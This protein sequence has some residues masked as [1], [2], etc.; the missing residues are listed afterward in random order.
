MT[1]MTRTEND[2][3][4]N[5]VLYMAMELSLKKWHLAFGN[6]IKKR[7]IIVSAADT[8]GLEMAIK[9]TKEKFG[10]D[11]STTVI[12]CYEAGRDGFWIHRYLTQKRIKNHVID[13]S[14]I[15][16]NRKARRAKTDRIDAEML[17]KKLIS[18]IRKED[19][20]SIARIP[21]E[22]EEDRRRM[23][24]EREAL[25]K[26]RTRHTNRIKSLL[27]LQGI[28]YEGKGRNSWQVYLEK[29][30][31]WKGDTIAQYQKEELTRTIERL[32]LIEKQLKTVE[33]GMWNELE[34]NKDPVFQRIKQLMNLK[35]IGEVSA[36]TLIMEWFGSG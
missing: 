15:D 20:L 4:N 30:Q 21:T 25:K 3:A 13:S 36:W 34:K 19:R 16:V 22:E 6:G 7:Q 29:I 24:R 8:Q 27:H 12:S 17:L 32:D 26:E 35:G 18:Y 10:M 2:T 9:K 28:M 23:H 14:S 5:T 1:E 31:D 33:T 11:E